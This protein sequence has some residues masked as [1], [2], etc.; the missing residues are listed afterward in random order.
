LLVATLAFSGP[1]LEQAKLGVLSAALASALL[2]WLLFRVT[3]RLSPPR[4][5]RVM[6]GSA[7]PI[8]DLAVPLDP[9]HDHT[10]GPADAPVTVVEYGD[11][12]CPYCG[13][14]EPVVRAL[15]AD[16]GDVRYVWR[17]LPLT[18]VHTHAQLAA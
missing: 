9:R 4:R 11:F 2:S 15:L 7:E 10:R 17:H 5:T 1:A 13:Q 3:A 14:A 12:E 6:L 18:D 16:F 8:I